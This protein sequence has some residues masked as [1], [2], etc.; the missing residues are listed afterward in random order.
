MVFIYPRKARV[1]YKTRFTLF[2]PCLISICHHPPP[3]SLLTLVSVHP[4][5]DNHILIFSQVMECQKEGLESS[6]LLCG[7]PGRYNRLGAET[8]T[9]TMTNKQPPSTI[10]SRSG[11]HYG[12]VFPGG[13]LYS[14]PSYG[15]VRSRH[16]K[17]RRSGFGELQW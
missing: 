6:S 4:S 5:T 16:W 17:L 1:N 7:P 9:T 15:E 13:T 3:A 14:C 2:S 10:I 8:L 12:E 11:S